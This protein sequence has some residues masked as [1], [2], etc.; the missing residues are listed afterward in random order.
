MG[1]PAPPAQTLATMIFDG[2]FERFPNLRVGVIEMGAVWVPFWMRQM[3]LRSTRSPVTKSASGCCRCARATTCVAKFVHSVPNRRRR[4]D[5]RT[6]RAF[7]HDNF[8]DM[9]GA[10]LGALHS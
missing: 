7:Y 1:I 2:V 9:M 6:S 8:V 4:L 3:E 10:G 5:H